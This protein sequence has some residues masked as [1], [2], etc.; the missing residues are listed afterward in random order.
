MLL[1]VLH[2]FAATCAV[3]TFF[4]IS[5]W[6]KYLVTAGRMTVNPDTGVCELNGFRWGGGGDIVLI[7]M[8]VLDILLRLSAVVAIGF[9][10]YGSIQYVTSDG[11][12]DRTK[13]AQSTIINALVGLVIAAIAAATVSFIGRSLSK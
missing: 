2:H 3:N 13:E 5:P 11:A 12:P 9:I 1:E 4:G 6:Y 8:G 10:I 7:F